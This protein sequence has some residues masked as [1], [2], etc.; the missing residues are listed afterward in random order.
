MES[1]HSV[2][3]EVA[4]RHALRYNI[5]VY[6]HCMNLSRIYAPREDEV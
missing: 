1:G 2:K 3:K 5:V 4:N 6:Y